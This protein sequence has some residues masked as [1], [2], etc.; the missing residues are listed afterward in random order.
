MSWKGR[1][2]GAIIGL[3]FGGF[4]AILGFIIGYFL[5]DKP[6]NTRLAQNQQARNTFGGQ[7]E[8]TGID[9]EI[10]ASTFC[11]MGYVSR[12]AGR[13]NESHIQH[14]E[15]LMDMMNLDVPMRQQAV[16]A[17]DYGKSDDF[18]LEK[19]CQHILYMIGD[20]VSMLSYLLEIQVGI[21]I[22]DEILSDGEH[23][24]LLNIAQGLHV[25]FNDMERLIRIRIAE[26]QFA[27]FSEQ[28]A[29]RRQREFE[30]SGHQGRYQEYGN[31][32]YDNYEKYG[33]DNEQ[34]QYGYS[35]GDDSDRSSRSSSSSWS[36]SSSELSHA[37]EILGV[38][39]DSSWDEI[40][41]AH[42]KLMLKYH[43]DRLAAQGLPPEMI[44]L[45]T[46]KSQ[47]IQ[48]AFSL[49]KEARGM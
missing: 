12:G 20:N 45:Y 10:I 34:K 23:E 7:G 49:I 14:A 26:Q 2:I 9:R 31:Q 48:A 5:V 38:S 44:K 37:Y 33:Y 8:R 36:N 39:S 11:L 22:A 35:S 47:D 30:Q 13:I 6:A 43:P 46:N 32:S 28:F 4:P 27:R 21:A 18:Q 16:K 42:K 17:F 1:V 25:N 15:S 40:R 3:L 24:R 41:K 29:R 19:E